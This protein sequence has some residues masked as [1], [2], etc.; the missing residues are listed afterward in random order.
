MWQNMHHLGEE[1]LTLKNAAPL[2]KIFKTHHGIRRD[3]SHYT[4]FFNLRM[5]KQHIPRHQGTKEVLG[6][7]LVQMAILMTMM[8]KTPDAI[9][10]WPTIMEQ[11]CPKRNFF[12]VRYWSLQ[13]KK[14][15][16]LTV[17]SK[18]NNSIAKVS[19][20]FVPFKY[21]LQEHHCGKNIHYFAKLYWNSIHLMV[22]I[23]CYGLIISTNTSGFI[24]E[25][26]G[27]KLVRGLLVAMMTSWWHHDD[28]TLHSRPSYLTP[29]GNRPWTRSLKKIHKSK[30][31]YSYTKNIR[32]WSN[33]APLFNQACGKPK[34]CQKWHFWAFLA[35]FQRFLSEKGPE[36]EVVEI[37]IKAKSSLFQ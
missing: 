13:Q 31:K 22:S 17:C 33:L 10:K 4:Y 27:K 37:Y 15:K 29:L 5:V 12:K 34:T 9:P 25:C 24:R 19:R 23:C 16:F 21:E 3:W 14:I 18:L 30:K 36:L 7:N 28:V 1:F 6:K 20:P 8:V 35:K 11:N 2:I 26:A 32:R